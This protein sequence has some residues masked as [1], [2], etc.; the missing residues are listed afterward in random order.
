MDR[1]DCEECLLS[2]DDDSVD[3]SRATSISK[4]T[5]SGPGHLNSIIYRESRCSTKATV[6]QEDDFGDNL[7]GPSSISASE[8][9]SPH[10]AKW[11][12]YASSNPCRKNVANGT[13][14]KNTD[15]IK[16][17]VSAESDGSIVSLQ[18]YHRHMKVG[19][20]LSLSTT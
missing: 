5:T 4:D 15:C 13:Y 2:S 11:L 20:E 10:K 9:Y 7:E 6:F 1:I 14:S 12:P 19:L 16:N 18:A 17:F 3:F 8:N